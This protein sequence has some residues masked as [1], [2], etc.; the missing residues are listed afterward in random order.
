MNK[1]D[2]KQIRRYEDID[3][4]E[5][6]ALKLVEAK[7]DINYEEGLLHTLILAQ[8]SAWVNYMQENNPEKAKFLKAIHSDIYSIRNRIKRLVQYDGLDKSINN[9]SKSNRKELRCNKNNRA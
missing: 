2:L 9:K 8:E 1:K 6:V 7:I 5:K 4:P 3:L